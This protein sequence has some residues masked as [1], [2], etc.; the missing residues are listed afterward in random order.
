MQFGLE[1]INWINGLRE[2]T[3]SFNG[4]IPVLKKDGYIE[5]LDPKQIVKNTTYL[6]IREINDISQSL[7]TTTLH[8]EDREIIKNLTFKLINKVSLQATK[9]YEKTHTFWFNA[10]KW[11]SFATVILIP[12][13]I[14]MQNTQHHAEKHLEEV[15]RIKDTYLISEGMSDLDINSAAHTKDFFKKSRNLQPLTVNKESIQ[16]PKQVERDILRTPSIRVNQSRLENSGT[17]DVDENNKK[18]L[19]LYDG[20]L[21][22]FGETREN[23]NATN[24]ILDLAISQTSA[25]PVVEKTMFFDNEN[26]I[27]TTTWKNRCIDIN[28]ID[29]KVTIH[30]KAIS[31]ETIPQVHEEDPVN[32]RIISRKVSFRLDELKDAL[33]T[34]NIDALKLTTEDLISEPLFNPAGKPRFESL[35]STT[36]SLYIPDEVAIKFLQNFD[37]EPKSDRPNWNA[38]DDWNKIKANIV[39]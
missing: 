20:F 9:T 36:S 33:I 14:S 13:G 29:G 24:A 2:A 17:G 10:L 7:L 23:S 21:K 3:T 39:V 35:I 8:I 6:G 22:L 34:N 25:V 27:H 30:T 28:L 16:I 18:T 38:N 37:Y 11:V 32:A 1:P 31:Y 15:K 19:H 4:D 26:N 12:V 5:I